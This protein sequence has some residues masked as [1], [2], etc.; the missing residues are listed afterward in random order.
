MSSPGTSQSRAGREAIRGTRVLKH[1]D[2]APPSL[3]PT[4]RVMK[5]KRSHLLTPARQ[6]SET[7]ERRQVV[8]TPSSTPAHDSLC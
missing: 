2:P 3:A 5:H 1:L 4:S 6:A 7:Q 8:P